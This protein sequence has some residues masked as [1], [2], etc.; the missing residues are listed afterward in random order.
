MWS[1]LR[2]EVSTAHEGLYKSR[3]ESKGKEEDWR[4]WSK[5]VT[6]SDLCF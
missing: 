5:R 1:E 2:S 3:F 4:A 6:G